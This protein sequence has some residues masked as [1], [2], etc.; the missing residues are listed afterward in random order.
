M[1][2]FTIYDSERNISNSFKRWRILLSVGLMLCLGQVGFAFLLADS[3]SN[4]ENA[5]TSTEAEIQAEDPGSNTAFA[6]ANNDDPAACL[7]I[8]SSTS[9]AVGYSIGGDTNQSLAG[10]FI[11]YEG[12]TFNIEEVKVSVNSASPSY[13]NV[14][15]WSDNAGLPDTVLYTLNNVTIVSSTPTSGGYYLTTLDISSENISLTSPVGDTRYWMQIQTDAT[16]WEHRAGTQLR[17]QDAF[18]YTNSAGVWTRINADTGNNDLVY[19]IIGECVGACIPPTAPVVTVNSLTTAT[20]SWVSDGDL[21]DVEWG[22]PGFV[23]GTGNQINEITT[24]STDLTVAAETPYEYYIRQDCGV[25]GESS[26]IGPFS[27]QTGYCIASST[28]ISDVITSFETTGGILNISNNTGTTISPGG[29]GNFTN[30]SVAHYETGTINFT[31]NFSATMGFN[32]WVDWNN[33]GTFEESEKVYASGITGN[34]FS[35]SFEVPADTPLGD[36]RMRVR[37]QWGNSDPLPC[38]DIS[39]GEAEDYTLTVIDPPACLPP[40]GLTATPTSLTEVTLGWTSAGNNFDLEWGPAGFTLG[41]GTLIND[42]TTTSTDVTVVI[43]TPYQFYVRQDCGV[44]GESLWAGPFNFQT[45]YCTPIYTSGCTNGAKITVFETADAVLNI[46]NVTGT[47]TCGIEGYDN[48]SNLA[49]AAPED[50]TVSFTVGVGSYS[51]GVKVWIDWNGNGEFEA[52]ELVAESTATIAAGAT[53]TGSFTVPTGTPLGDYILR[54]RIVES[55]TTFTAC[56]SQSWGETEDYTITVITPPTCMPPTGLGVAGVTFNTAD[57]IWT[58]TGSDFEVEYGVQ[59]FTQGDGTLVTG[60]TTNGTVLSG[61]LAETAYQYYVRQDCGADGHSYWAGPYSFF[62]GYCQ[63]SST[64]TGNRI[65]DFSTSDGYTNISNL[66]NGTNNAYSNFSNLSVTQSEG[67]SFNYA[68]SVPSYTNIE[69]WIDYNNN[70]IFDTDELVAQHVYETSATTFTGTISLPASIDDGDYRIRVRSRY[71]WQT[72]ASPCGNVTYGEAE[73]YTLT[74]VPL[75]DCLPPTGLTATPTSLTEVTLGWTSA[76]NNFDVEWGPAGF[77]LGDGTLISDITTTSTDV[78]VVIDT[79][80]QFYVRQ[81]C[82]VDGESLWTGPFN[83]QTGYCTPIYTSGCTNGAKITLFE[84]A[85]AVLNISNETGATS[86]GVNGYNN[87]SSFAAAAPEEMTVS[88]T[89]GI[90]SYSAGV[91]V[92]I[93]WDANGVFDAS[94]LVSE[95]TGTIAAGGI[96]TGSFTVPTGTP[97]GDYRIRVRAVESTTVFTACSSQSWGEAEDYPITVITPPSCMPPTGLTA[98]PTSLTEVMLAWTS[99]EDNFDLEWGPAGFTLGDGTQMYGL[100]TNSTSLEV[101]ID[102]PYQFYVRQNCGVDDGLSLWAGPFNFK[103]GYCMPLYTWGCSNGAKISNFETFD[104]LDNI[105][106]NT[107]T[108]FCGVDGYNNF[109]TMSATVVEGTT[110][111]FVVGVGSY[112]AGVKLWVDWNNNGVFDTD[113][114]VSQSPGTIASGSNY[115]SSFTI[116]MGT[117]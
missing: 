73:D 74:I 35:G 54:V 2:N 109:T 94:E 72:V 47:D 76:G 117:Q 84:T 30:L 29:Y 77:T 5:F 46:N 101:T 95:S 88:F 48:F 70:M 113:E 23:L 63:V 56:S 38:G 10:D 6:N 51:A 7:Q 14:I 13:F 83:F 53:F 33:N 15:F 8:S 3:K 99:T 81:D 59:G 105:A 32:I 50:M 107:G 45:G 85:D 108:G 82:G 115:T 98:T 4:S 1:K 112:G 26:W 90:G 96:Y 11:V 22:L 106:N 49:A 28:N 100:T 111:P 93:D 67:G 12:I 42:I 78:T 16:G 114:I 25:D 110:V 36:Y 39:W 87:F 9:N 52:S 103:T 64:W 20:L 104:A 75:P 61:L 17:T 68:V 97:L 34:P 66:N 43:D 60:I 79:P 40:S 57:L 102:T 24:T 41:D 44:D 71:Y 37:A 91:K 86:C 21:F 18:F 89:V 19:E 80:Y 116:P 69:I 31:T 27:F 58:S 92:W 62:T 65:T 55:T